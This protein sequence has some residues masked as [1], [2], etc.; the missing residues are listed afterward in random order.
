[1]L[2]IQQVCVQM[3]NAVCLRKCNDIQCNGQFDTA[4]SIMTRKAWYGGL[5][6]ACSICPL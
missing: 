5:D 4:C 3:R 6:A 2:A 1:M